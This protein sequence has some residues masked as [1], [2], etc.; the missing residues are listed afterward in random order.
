MVDLSFCLFTFPYFLIYDDSH[1]I[2]SAGCK[3]S[4][5]FHHKLLESR[6]FT[7]KNFINSKHLSNLPGSPRL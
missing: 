5:N 2:F 7:V 6:R 3:V 4:F 1:Y